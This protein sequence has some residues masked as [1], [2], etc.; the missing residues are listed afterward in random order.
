MKYK[1]LIEKLLPFSEEDISMAVS[2]EEKYY[3]LDAD[4]SKHMHCFR[5]KVLS[6]I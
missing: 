2:D 4:G 3:S 5:G 1:D 6:S